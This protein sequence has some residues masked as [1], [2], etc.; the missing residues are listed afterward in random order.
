M[1]FKKRKCGGC[2]FLPFANDET[3]YRLN[4]M[5]NPSQLCKWLEKAQVVSIFHIID[6]CGGS[7]CTTTEQCER[8]AAVKVLM[9]KKWHLGE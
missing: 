2:V 3:I 8:A 5:K 6:V 7:L 1:T 4:S 9:Q